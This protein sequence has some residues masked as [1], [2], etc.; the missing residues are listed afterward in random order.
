MVAGTN[1]A[2]RTRCPRSLRPVDKDGRTAAGLRDALDLNAPNGLAVA[3]PLAPPNS[4]RLAA[5]LPVSSDRLAA[6][7]PGSLDLIMSAREG[8]PSN[9]L[10]HKGSRWHHM[11]SAGATSKAREGAEPG[12]VPGAKGRFAVE[13]AVG[14]RRAIQHE[15]KRGKQTKDVLSA[16][17]RIDA[18]LDNPLFASDEERAAVSVQRTARG[19]LLRLA[20][21]RGTLLFPV[22]A[23]A[24]ADGRVLLHN[25]YGARVYS[26]S[27]PERRQAVVHHF[28][29]R[30][31]QRVWRKHALSAAR[32]RPEDSCI[33]V[34]PEDSLLNVTSGINYIDFACSK[35]QAESAVELLQLATRCH[36]ARKRTKRMRLRLSR[37]VNFLRFLSTELS[38]ATATDASRIRIAAALRMQACWRGAVSR[39]QFK[40][41]IGSRGCAAVMLQKTVRGWSGRRKMAKILER[42]LLRRMLHFWNKVMWTLYSP[43]KA[44]PCHNP[45]APARCFA[46]DEA[47]LKALGA[48]AESNQENENNATPRQEQDLVSPPTKEKKKSARSDAGEEDSEED[49]GRQRSLWVEREEDCDSVMLVPE[50]SKREAALETPRQSWK[51]VQGS[52]SPCVMMQAPPRGT[53]AQGAVTQQTSAARVPPMQPAWPASYSS[54]VCCEPG[55]LKQGELLLRARSALL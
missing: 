1:G 5:G 35:E 30:H 21:K 53:N 38:T 32:L 15:W 18:F 51:V 29:A 24:L 13:D 55:A 22:E 41:R 50:E 2:V 26:L 31:L 37:A 54:S 48:A 4:D 33:S 11:T 7:L 34:A 39:R 3:A 46:E 36:L 20:R 27:P 10:P 12:Q 45:G 44:V 19:W 43:C 8:K 42:I 52:N 47:R 23:Q 40:E 16:C 28:A 17:A 49:I 9:K 14:T 25:D 6:G